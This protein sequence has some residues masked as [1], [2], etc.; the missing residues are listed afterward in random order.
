MMFDRAGAK[1]AARERLRQASPSPILVTLVFLLLTTGASTLV[2]QLTVDPLAEMVEYI[3][4]WGYEPERVIRYVLREMGPKALSLFCTANVLLGLWSSVMK[5]GYT[6]YAMGLAR[7]EE[8]GIGR[9][10]DGFSRFGRVLWMNVLIGLFTALWEVV[11]MLPGIAVCILGAVTQ[12]YGLIMLSVLVMV[13]G[14]AVMGAWAALRYA[15][16]PYFLLD[17]DPTAREAI[18]MSKAAMAG[19]KLELFWLYVSFFGWMFLAGL[20]GSIAM[21][22]AEWTGLPMWLS[23]A[24]AGVLMLWLDPYMAC[25]EA[26]FYDHVRPGDDLP[27]LSGGTPGGYRPNYDYRAKDSGPEPF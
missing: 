11:G 4:E 22:F 8:M 2:G 10:F 24:A 1:Q 20:V 27:P 19:W 21:A 14:G 7:G 16:S 18:S 3:Y 5:V 9:L 6:S 17:F 15:L 13:A 23:T 26:E 25:T 12:S